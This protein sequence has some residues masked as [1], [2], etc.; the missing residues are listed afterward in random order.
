MPNIFAVRGKEIKIHVFTRY[1]FYSTARLLF[2]FLQCQIFA[3]LT[4]TY[5]D[6]RDSHTTDQRIIKS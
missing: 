6:K 5:N 3:C 4:I 1:V 2:S